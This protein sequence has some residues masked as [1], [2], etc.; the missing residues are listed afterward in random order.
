VSETSSEDQL[1]AGGPPS[2][3]SPG[4]AGPVAYQLPD[5]S[6]ITVG[7]ERLAVPELLF[8]PSPLAGSVPG[9]TGLQNSIL[10]SAMACDPELRRDLLG[11]M[12]LT[13]AASALPGVQERLMAEFAPMAPVGTRPKLAA[14]SAGERALGAWLGGSIVGSLG[15]FTE[16]W[17]ARS[18]YAE[19]GA[20]MVHLKCP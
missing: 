20:K 17:F 6:T 1:A 4:S 15:G 9:A 18:E 10:S 14:A 8:D 13:G 7:G 5:G 12:V 3:A 19:H 16:L 11:N 2:L